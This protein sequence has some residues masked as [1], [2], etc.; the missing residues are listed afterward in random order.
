LFSFV[1]PRLGGMIAVVETLAEQ[2]SIGGDR[3]AKSAAQNAKGL[4]TVQ[5]RA[6]AFNRRNQIAR[7]L[8]ARVERY[9]VDRCFRSCRRIPNNAAPSA[10]ITFAEA[11]Y[12]DSHTAS[13]IAVCK[14]G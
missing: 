13:F 14:V 3:R 12:H 9:N 11:N 8:G 5:E 6:V 7:G 4:P 1:M 2:S 10:F